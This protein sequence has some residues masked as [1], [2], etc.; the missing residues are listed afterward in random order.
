M[1]PPHTYVK[2]DTMIKGVEEAFFQ[3]RPTTRDS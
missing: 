1:Y 3:T 2:V